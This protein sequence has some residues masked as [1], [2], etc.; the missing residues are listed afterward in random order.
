MPTT[1]SSSEDSGP[2]VERSKR[3]WE[4]ADKGIAELR[5][6]LEASEV[7]Q[8]NRRDIMHVLQTLEDIKSEA[9]YLKDDFLWRP[10]F[11]FLKGRRLSE[12]E[13]HFVAS[14]GALYWSAKFV[15]LAPA[16]DYEV[17]DNFRCEIRGE[18][19]EI[20]TGPLETPPEGMGHIRVSVPP[21]RW[22]YEIQVSDLR[23]EQAEFFQRP[24]PAIY[25]RFK[26]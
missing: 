5:A 13:F 3:I 25:T 4:L 7:V 8:E 15:G 18:V 17:F 20:D 2:V 24:L 14:L 6:R 11:K 1:Q 9:T 19:F 22:P 23:P 26:K 21:K 12:S 16:T 10:L